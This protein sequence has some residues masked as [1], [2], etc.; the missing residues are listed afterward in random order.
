V[1]IDISSVVVHQMRATFPDVPRLYWLVMDCTNMGFDDDHF[2]IVFDKG[3]ID[4]L[5]CDTSCLG[6]IGAT[7]RQIYRVLK[8]GGLS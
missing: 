7:L 3:T 1:N 5:M 4:A 6:P 8:P 2:D